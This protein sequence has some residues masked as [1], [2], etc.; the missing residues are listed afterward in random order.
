[1]N[2]GRAH[3]VRR[4]GCDD[5]MKE[6]R[7]RREEQSSFFFFFVFFFL[8]S[9]CFCVGCCAKGVDVCKPTPLPFRRE[10]KRINPCRAAAAERDG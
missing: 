4:L 8:S 7:K 5:R 1:M 2:R 6:R 10:G 9:L 3:R